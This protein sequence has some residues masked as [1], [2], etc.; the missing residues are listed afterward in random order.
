MKR[1]RL[2]R[3]GFRWLPNGSH[4]TGISNTKTTATMTQQTGTAAKKALTGL[5]I[6]D[7][8]KPIAELAV[9]QLGGNYAAA[10][11][12]ARQHTTQATLTDIERA[13]RTLQVIKGK[14]YAKAIE[15]ETGSVPPGTAD[16]GITQMLHGMRITVAELGAW[17]TQAEQTKFQFTTF[18][19]LPEKADARQLLEDVRT[20]QRY[21]KEAATELTRIEQESKQINEPVPL[22]AGGVRAAII[23]GMWPLFCEQH[24]Q[25]A[26]LLLEWEELPQPARLE[27]YYSL[28]EDEKLHVREQP[29]EE[30]REKAVQAFFDAHHGK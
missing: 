2:K 19:P 17:Y 15:K 22:A 7:G 16:L 3:C 25:E 28:P 5:K 13:V 30:K 18:S 21:T 27:Y 11:A 24:K 26:Y 9:R 1:L 12:L 29:T 14:T 20:Q 8:L 23:L 4:S 6:S 10:K